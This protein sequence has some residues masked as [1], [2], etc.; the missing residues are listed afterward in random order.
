ML[1]L[2]I[3]NR[4][5]IKKIFTLSVTLD[6]GLKLIS[7]LGISYYSILIHYGYY[8]YLIELFFIEIY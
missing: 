1:I 8:N 3:K 7:Y 5:V 4:K 2:K 6:K